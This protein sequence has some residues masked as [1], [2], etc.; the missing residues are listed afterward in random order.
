MEPI[1]IRTKVESDTLRLPQLNPLI[2]RTV[3]I[4]IEEAPAPAVAEAFYAAVGRIP[5]TEAEWDSRQ[6]TLKTWRTD[7]R[8]ESY[9]PVID[10]MLATDFA[11]ARRWAAAAEAIRGLTDYDFEAWRE[12]REFDRLHAGDPLP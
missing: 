12:Q 8:F 1:R 9:W 10:H 2:G 3:E 5:E 4:T 7:P 11:S 6:E